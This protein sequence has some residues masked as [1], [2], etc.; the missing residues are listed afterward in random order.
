MAKIVA[1]QNTR[2]VA[3]IV[4][5]TFRATCLAKFYFRQRLW[6]LVSQ[7]FCLLQGMIHLKILVQLVP[8]QC[9]QNIVRQVAWNISQC[10]NALRHTYRQCT[11][12]H[13]S[14]RR[15]GT[16]EKYNP[17]KNKQQ[18]LHVSE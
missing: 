16:K 15:K 8:P 4:S 7:Q 9:C 2:K 1:R 12:C 5:P 13:G 11:Y 17:H 14:L 10:I 3:L 6:Q 18:E